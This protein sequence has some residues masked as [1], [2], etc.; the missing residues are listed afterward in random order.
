M[1]KR[2]CV[3]AVMDQESAF[4]RALERTVRYTISDE[5]FLLLFDDADAEVL[6]LAPHESDETDGD[7]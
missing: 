5:G 7:G 1:T 3:P 6:R 2:M 4:T